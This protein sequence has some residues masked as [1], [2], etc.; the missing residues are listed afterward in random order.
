M[1]NVCSYGILKF[2]KLDNFPN[3]I[4]EILVVYKTK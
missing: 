4:N 3:S 1:E 2:H